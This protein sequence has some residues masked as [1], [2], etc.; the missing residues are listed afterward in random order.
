MS[1]QG[2]LTWKQSIILTLWTVLT[3]IVGIMA[4]LGGCYVIYVL[5]ITNTDW[6]WVIPVGCM[7]L[8]VIII[9]TPF[10]RWIN[11]IGISKKDRDWLK[12]G[13]I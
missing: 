3:I 8:S 6:N 2:K 1:K 13:E 5:G 11:S 7:T 12:G 10:F 4:F 9:F